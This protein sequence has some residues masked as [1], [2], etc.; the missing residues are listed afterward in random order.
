MGRVCSAQGENRNAYRLLVGMTEEK[1]SLGRH[2]HAWK[3]T[4][5]MNL[6]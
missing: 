1:R 5:K 4:I 6:R 3:D 2:M